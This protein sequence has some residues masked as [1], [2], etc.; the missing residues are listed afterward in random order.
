MGLNFR[1]SITL[2]KGIK[3]NLSKSGA[4]LSF[5]GKGFRKTISTKGKVTTTVGIPGTGIYYTDTDNLK[6][7]KKKTTKKKT[8]KKTT[9]K[10]EEE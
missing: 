5:G 3:L 2:F 10:N 7:K 8:T 6:S 9:K 4:S 1:K